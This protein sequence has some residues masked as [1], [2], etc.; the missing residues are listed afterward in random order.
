MTSIKERDSVRSGHTFGILAV[1]ETAVVN[2]KELKHWLQYMMKG[3][4]LPKRY[5]CKVLIKMENES[6]F[7]LI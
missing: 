4:L 6:G 2:M 7:V 1:K 5:S 3:W